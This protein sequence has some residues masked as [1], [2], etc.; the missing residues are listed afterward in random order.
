MTGA[1]EDAAA[2]DDVPGL[3]GYID[4]RLGRLMKILETPHS[5]GDHSSAT[6]SIPA[7]R[8]RRRR[9]GKKKKVRPVKCCQE[10]QD[11]YDDGFK[12]HR[13]RAA[14]QALA[15]VP[16]RRRFRSSGESSG[17][18]AISSC[19]CP[20]LPSSSRPSHWGALGVWGGARGVAQWDGV[21][22]DR[23]DDRLNPNA[24][25]T[26]RTTAPP[27]PNGWA[28]GAGASPGIPNL[29]EVCSLGLPAAE[30]R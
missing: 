29:R 10:L 24:P 9:K 26:F 21:T 30:F 8:E 5:E 3:C 7:H 25:S 2:D 19:Y 1:V 17:R 23:P 14:L 27:R 20:P 6:C 28:F 12:A 11:A 18:D 15:P 22:S 16:A 4:F 13:V